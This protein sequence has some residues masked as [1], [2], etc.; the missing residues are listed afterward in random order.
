[1][2]PRP[3][4][5]VVP[6]RRPDGLVAAYLSEP[7][8]PF[9]CELSGFAP[10]D[11][12]E[13]ALADS[14]H[15]V[16]LLTF[17]MLV[18]RT[19]SGVR[20]DV[21]RGLR[22]L[23]SLHLLTALDDVTRE[24]LRR[25]ESDIRRRGVVDAERRLMRAEAVQDP[26]VRQRRVQTAMVSI[27][28]NGVSRWHSYLAAVRGL[29]DFASDIGIRLHELPDDPT[30]GLFGG[31]GESFARRPL[32]E[33]EMKTVWDAA[34]SHRDPELAVLVLDLVRETAARR[35][36]VIDLTLDDV[37]WRQSYVTLHTKFGRKV[38][39]VVSG[40][41]MERI[42]VRAIEQ[43]WDG[44]TRS[45]ARNRDPALADPSRLALRRSN[46][47]PLTKRWFDGLFNHIDRRCS[48]QLDVRITTHWLRHT[49][50]AQVAQIAG[51]DVA[52]QWAG[53]RV[54]G[55]GPSRGDA[56]ALYIRWTLSEL[57]HL[58]REMFPKTPP[59]AVDPVVLADKVSWLN[60]NGLSD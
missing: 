51:P 40:D 35:Q 33:T 12:P 19:R 34:A 60:T 1:M 21:Y 15:S 27:E 53:H 47:E 48:K 25:D 2:R 50:I 45:P 49:T 55:H 4:T 28:R 17:A 58:F 52:S 41:L 13:R 46:G 31:G 30:R 38:D 16:G 43:G 56:T 6:S 10:E 3:A 8:D 44:H 36:A 22:D 54:G 23:V 37:H 18:F 14:S 39:A 20:P 5:S 24:L 7:W 11:F 59:H 26:L 42:A 9:G 29:R 32:S 57:K